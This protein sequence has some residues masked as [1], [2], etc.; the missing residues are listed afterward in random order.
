MR[1]PAAQFRRLFLSISP[2]ETTFA[3]RGFEAKHP[4]AQRRLEKIGET[5][6]RGYHEALEETESQ[7][8]AARLDTIDLELR[9]LAFEGAAMALALLDCLTPWKSNR[10]QSFLE[11]PA[12]AHAYMVHVGVGWA[13]ARLRRRGE[14]YVGRLDPLLRWLVYD[15]YGFHEGYFHR[16][17]SVDRRETP[18]RLRGYARRVFD[19]GLG[20]SLWFVKGADADGILDTVS[21]FAEAR[22]GDLWSG[23]GLACAYAGG[24]EHAGI[25]AI[26]TACAP[27]TPQVAQGAAFAA[28]TRQRAG[29]PAA[30]T[31][32]ACRILCGLPAE[33]AAEI[34]DRAL[35]SLPVATSE[36]PAYEWWRKRV[37]GHLPAGRCAA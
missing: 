1:S 28:K 23:V 15:G 29:N 5:F 6:A 11:G 18:R 35:E 3:R 36:D 2:R 25:E 9:G 27:Y 19:Q 13:L 12:A 26:R 8:L 34:T 10:I 22:R 21:G 30:H 4:P 37:Q 33:A 7:A 31:E 16:R 24:V 32:D 17:R 14:R 20:R